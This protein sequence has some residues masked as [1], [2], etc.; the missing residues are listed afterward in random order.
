LKVKALR[1]IG[2]ASTLSCFVLT[3]TA[4][5]SF[6][7]KGDNNFANA[8]AGVVFGGMA[9]LIGLYVILDSF[10]HKKLSVPEADDS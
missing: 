2:F 10:L 5:M 6:S 8:L 3:Q 9:A 1:A 4:I 7:N